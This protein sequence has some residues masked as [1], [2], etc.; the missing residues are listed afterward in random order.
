MTVIVIV[1]ELYYEYKLFTNHYFIRRI[2]FLFCLE[3]IMG[4]TSLQ[5]VSLKKDQ[6]RDHLKFLLVET[7]ISHAFNQL[8]SVT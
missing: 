1:I 4:C 3:D 7:S 6:L 2:V 5:D 8:F